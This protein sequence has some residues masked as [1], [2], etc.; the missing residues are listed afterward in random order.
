M[1]R[2]PA[3]SEVAVSEA[4]GVPPVPL[5][6][7]AGLSSQQAL[8]RLEAVGP[9]EP[10][11]AARSG[12]LAQ[13]LAQFANPLVIVL[14]V[15]SLVSALVGEATSATIIVVI[16]LLG[17]AITFVQTYRSQ[18]AIVRLRAVVATTATVLRDGQWR[19]LPRREIVPG[20]VIRLSA[21]DLVPADARL[22]SAR[23]LHVQQA[24]LTGESMPVE[25]EATA[26]DDARNL[27]FMGTSVVGGTAEALVTA[28]G[29]K[30]AFGNIAARLATRSPETEF[31][32]GMRQ[33]GYLILRTV[34][35][36][37]LLVFLVNVVL[38]RDPLE[39][40]LF[41]VAL[42]VGL[43]P[44]FLPMI[45]AVTLSRGAVHMAR[46]QV[47]VKH[48][49]SIQ[50]F[51]SMDI[52]C[53]DKTGTL[54]SGEMRLDLAADQAGQPSERPLRLAYLNS[55]HETGIKS[56]LDR[57]ILQHTW[58]AEV[59]ADLA[60]YEKIDEVPFDFERRRLS[61]VVA[62]DGQRLLVAK[63][64]PEG[65]LEICSRYQQGDR[66]QPLD[67]GARD[68]CRQTVDRLSADGYR[69]L[70]VAFRTVPVQDAYRASDETDLTL[71]GYLAFLDPPLADVAETLAA[72]RQ[73]GVT[74][75]ILTGDSE[76][77]AQHVCRQVGLDVGEIVLGTEVDHMTDTALGHVAEQT[78]IFARVTPVQKNRILLAL[79]RRGHVVGYLGDGINDAPS[80]HASDV[81]ISVASA[82]DVARDAA[83][84]ILLQGGL[85]VLHA[86][87]IE[88][89]QA[90][91]NVMKYLLMGTSS[92]FG[93]M[94]SMAGAVLFL[95]FLPMLPMQ[96]LLNNF[97]YDVSQLTIPTDRV[98]ASF[99]HKPKRWDIKLIRN[100]MLSIGPI[101]S[102]YDMLTFA[103]L[104]LVFQASEAMFHT[105]WFVESLATQTLVIFVVRTGGN[106][107]RSRPSPALAASV[108]GVVLLGV[109]LPYTPLAEP[110]GFVSLPFKY[111]VFLGGVTVT[112]LALV[113]WIKRLLFRR[114]FE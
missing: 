13:L 65:I 41:S 2:P 114:F 102:L 24:S 28:T 59:Q 84:I 14:L 43:T 107:L 75:K 46:R 3:A 18:R 57:A 9:N 61:I 22:L 50:N 104:L 108:V 21:G 94:F 89:R 73:D 48:L 70:A 68:A 32:R 96:I 63:G 74:V 76:L 82:V 5:A 26:A 88:G 78:A 37:I 6:G 7:R 80:L 25:K 60:A 58:P 97:L 99:T 100:F 1:Q 4:G 69:V 111:L 35:V 39:S 92:N 112:Y 30:T 87:I 81:G 109:V 101:S 72:L 103:V 55:M 83:D 47:I 86:G 10:A 29:V 38:K 11:P 67:E 91:G 20:D 33:F 93:N 51:G 27:V 52:L 110:L 34:I 113:E 42:A 12:L 36:L 45:T 79:K 85:D 95:P 54:T 16:V 106:P 44:E 53:S 98:D 62:R 17:A 105:G 40:L 31:D 77:V 90:F 15:A 19:E 64:S 8:E 71:V 66:E 49:S 56:P 23:D